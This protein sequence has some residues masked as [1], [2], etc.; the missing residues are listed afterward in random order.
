MA[1]ADPE[2]VEKYRQLIEGGSQVE[3][4]QEEPISAEDAAFMKKYGLDHYD[5]DEINDEPA[6]GIVESDPYNKGGEEPEEDEDDVIKPTDYLLAVGKSIDPDSS[7]EVHI[8]D[9]VEKAFYPHHEY[10]IPSFP[11]C[12][13]WMPCAPYTRV[14]GSYCAVSSMLPHIEIWNMNVMESVIPVTWLT[15]H[16]DAVPSVQ[17]NHLD[18]DKLLSV[19]VDQTVRIWDLNTCESTAFQVGADEACPG[20]SGEWSRHHYSE[21]GI[22]SDLGVFGYD[23]RAAQTPQWSVLSGEMIDTFAWNTKEYQFFSATESGEVYWFDARSLES[24]IGQLS[25]HN[26]TVSGIAVSQLQERNIVATI[27]TDGVCCIWELTDG[28]AKIKQ[29][30]NM[31][32]Q[33]LLTCQFCPDDAL[34]LAVGGST[35]ET[36]IWDLK[37]DLD[38][39]LGDYRAPPGEANDEEEDD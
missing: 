7:L 15:G 39:D 25:A 21:F 24:P 5:E 16:T 18:A 27:G 35:A 26:K 29:Q 32:M 17:F 2:I 36:R 28:T 22:G 23:A 31:G 11:L 6:P 10:M 20:K 37:E 9:G 12:I 19:S 34:L 38:V 4:P 8:F 30:A 1:D 13:T 33:E 3:A 14:D